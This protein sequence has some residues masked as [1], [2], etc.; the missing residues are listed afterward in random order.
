MEKPERERCKYFEG[1]EERD[2]CSAPLCPLQL[3]PIRKWFADEEICR[4]R[5]Y[6]SL[7]WVKKQKKIASLELTADDEYFDNEILDSIKSITKTLQGVNPDLQDG[8]EKW[9]NQRKEKRAE[10]AEKRRNNKA[11]N[12][13]K[14]PTPRVQGR[15][16]NG[17]T[18]GY[19]NRG[20]N[21]C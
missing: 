10:V 18:H 16:K 9:L 8:K 21:N 14:S 17:K 19:T 6:Q 20:D 15:T 3:H 1:N 4:S 5:K 7:P 11:T 12:G 13:K 2:G